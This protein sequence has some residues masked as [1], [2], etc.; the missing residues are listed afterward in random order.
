MLC[1]PPGVVEP[2]KDSRAPK[3]LAQCPGLPLVVSKIDVA[4]I[5]EELSEPLQGWIVSPLPHL[6]NGRE[7]VLSEPLCLLLL[8]GGKAALTGSAIVGG[9]ILWRWFLSVF[10]LGGHTLGMA[11]LARNGP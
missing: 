6:L 2:P 1:S 9:G 7:D 10:V 4:S 3:E 5:L 11:P 8:V